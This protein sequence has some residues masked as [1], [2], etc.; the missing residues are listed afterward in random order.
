VSFGTHFGAT[1]TRIP[2]TPSS[3]HGSPISFSL[4]SV[5]VAVFSGVLTAQ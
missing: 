4:Q 2:D 5:S 3:F 1:I